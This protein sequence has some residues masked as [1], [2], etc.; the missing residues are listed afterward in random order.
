MKKL[1]VFFYIDA[2]NSSFLTPDVMPFLS[3][4]A[5][6]HSIYALENILGYSFAIQSCMLSG[7]Q[8]DENNH[9]MPYFYCPE[10]SPLMF[11]ILNLMEAFSLDKLQ[12]LRYLIVRE[13]RRLFFNKGVQANNIPL[14]GIGKISL[15]PYYYMCELPFFFELRELL[16]EK[17]QTA[18]TYIGPPKRRT[19]LHSVLFEHLR[20]S[21][22]ENELI[23]IYHDTLDGLGHAFGPNSPQYFNSAKSLDSA[24]LAT[25]RKL[26]NSLGKHF[27]LL[28]FSDHGQAELKFQINILSELTKKGLKLGVDYIC[29]VD[30]TLALFWPEDDA[31]KETIIGILNKIGHGVVIDEDLRKKYHLNF[32]DDRYG[33]IIFVLKP[34]GTFVPN[35]FSPFNAMKGLHGYFPEED[36]QK[37]FLISSARLPYYCAH[38]KDLKNL[39]LNLF[40]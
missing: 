27:T 32:K 29:F 34:G 15:Y 1:V 3:S 4:F 16:A 28:V 12:T 20:K 26:T 5:K 24:L 14:C 7:K 37:S 11:K 19:N 31:A 17:S 21:K 10:K 23:I 39:F 25:Y 8:P 36:V 6:K 9:W 35:F 33:E 30:A 22:H 18:V 40:Q 13:S 2:L 38:I